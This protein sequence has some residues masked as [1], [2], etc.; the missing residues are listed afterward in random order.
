MIATGVTRTLALHVFIGADVA[1]PGAGLL[2]LTRQEEREIAQLF[3]AACQVTPLRTTFV[4][5][6]CPKSNGVNGAK[7]WPG[8]EA[9]PAGV[10]SR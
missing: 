2:R 3:G 7:E 1:A 8:A 5:R 4:P 10:V 6:P 9:N